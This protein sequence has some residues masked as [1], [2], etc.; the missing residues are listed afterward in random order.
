MIHNNKIEKYTIN[1]TKTIGG[2][3]VFLSL[4]PWYSFGLLSGDSMPW[5][6]MGYFLFL[7][8]LKSSIKV[9]KNFIIFFSILVTGIIVALLF[10]S[11]IFNENI[12]RSL[13][14]Y[15]GVVVFYIGFYNYLQKYGFPI[16]IFIFA[17]LVWLLFGLFELFLPDLA[18][19]FSSARTDQGRG[20]TSLSPEATFFGIYLFFSSWLIISGEKYNISQYILILLLINIASIFF[21]AKS[22]MVILY[23]LIAGAVFFVY[24]YFRLIWK[25]QVIKR[26]FVIAAIMLLLIPIM[27]QTLENSRIMNLYEQIQGELSLRVIFSVDESLNSRLEHLVYSIHGSFNNFL[28][29]AGFDNFIKSGDVFD[30]T[31]DY[32]FYYNQPT[33]KIMSWNGDWLYQLGIFGLI[34]LVYLFYTSSDGSRFRRAELFL[35]IVLLLSAIPLAFPMIPML[36]ALYTYQSKFK[37]K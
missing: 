36:L 9:P 15:F 34:F 37:F 29:P 24:T 8:S 19:I 6:F 28:I 25:K 10:S 7:C 4:I 11:N 20:V 1:S 13:Y 23:L 18:S 14:N 5:P 21:L 3:A 27:D 16:H 31:Y 35:L 17:N 2:L 32:Y 12:F 30:A 33:N 26:T 22:S